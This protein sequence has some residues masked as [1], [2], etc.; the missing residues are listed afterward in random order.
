MVGGQPVTYGIAQPQQYSTTQYTSYNTGEV[1]PAYHTTYTGYSG[2]AADHA[3]TN[4]PP[5]ITFGGSNTQGS[6]NNK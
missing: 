5:K 4:A 1:N 3:H 6:I 2:T